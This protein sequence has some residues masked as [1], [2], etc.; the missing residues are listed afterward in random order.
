MNCKIV[1]SRKMVNLYVWCSMSNN[2]ESFQ[3]VP[4]KQ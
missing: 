1:D 3:W 4:Q 2:S